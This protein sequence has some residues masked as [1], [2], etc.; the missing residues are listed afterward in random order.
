MIIKQIAVGAG[1]TV[2][3]NHHGQIWTWGD[4]DNGRL[5][6]G[7]EHDCFT[8]QLVQAMAHLTVQQVSCYFHT[9]AV[10]QKKIIENDN[11]N[12]NTNGGQVYSWGYNHDGQCGTG[13]QNNH[14]LPQLVRGFNNQIHV[15]K[16]S[17]GQDH[18]AVLTD[19]GKVYCWGYNGEGQL[20]IG[21]TEESCVLLP[22]KVDKLDELI[23][24]DV[25]CGTYHTLAY[26][27]PASLPPNDAKPITVANHLM[28]NNPDSY[29]D[30]TFFV[31]GETVLAHRGILS[32]RSLYFA[33][34]FRSPMQEAND[35]IATIPDMERK[36][37]VQVLDYLYSGCIIIALE[38]AV[39]L[40]MAADRFCLDEL[41]QLCSSSFTNQLSVATVAFYLR[42]TDTMMCHDLKTKCF[43]FIVKHFKEVIQ[44][45]DNTQVHLSLELLWEICKVMAER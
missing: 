11:T 17:C 28:V 44:L 10:I 41:K 15:V 21:K 19:H 1:H 26:V 36:H 18:S 14:L 32:Q 23:V 20:G 42:K 13:C 8:P 24:W 35:G 40:Y 30:F 39:E 27:D 43:K 6:H 2:A 45:G 9:I 16:A 34:L 12:T 3:L 25:S 29:P 22:R 37:F 33:N 7:N 31:D 5:G 38:D 4:G